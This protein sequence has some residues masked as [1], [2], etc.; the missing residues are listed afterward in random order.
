[1]TEGDIRTATHHRGEETGSDS[2]V[3]SVHSDDDLG[4]PAVSSIQGKGRQTK[5]LMYRLKLHFHPNFPAFPRS[6]LRELPR[7]PVHDILLSDS[8]VLRIWAM[9]LA[10]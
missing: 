9:I 3:T 1:M 4:H 5:K 6:R 2:S 8:G 10:L 7:V